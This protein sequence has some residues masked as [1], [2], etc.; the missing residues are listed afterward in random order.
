MQSDCEKMKDQIA[1]LVAASLSDP[2]VRETEQHLSECAT[3]RDYAQA[4]R[5]QDIRLTE[6]IDKVDSDMPGRQNRVLRTID[7]HCR[8]GKVETLPLRRAIMRNPIT[9]VAAAAVIIFAAMICVSEI[10]ESI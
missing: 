4:L 9:R 10:S 8:S 3:C 2:Q 7:D 5:E 6:F 1:D